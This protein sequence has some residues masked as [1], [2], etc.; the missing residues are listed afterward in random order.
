MKLI[1]ADLTAARR[2]LASV[3]E[4]CQQ[5]AAAEDPRVVAVALAVLAKQ[6]LTARSAAAKEVRADLRNL[7]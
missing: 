6:S 1:Q 7:T 2:Y 3:A 4:M 5:A